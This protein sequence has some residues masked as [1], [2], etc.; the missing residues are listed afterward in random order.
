MVDSEERDFSNDD[1]DSDDD[2]SQLY[3]KMDLLKEKV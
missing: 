1:S 3:I 2:D